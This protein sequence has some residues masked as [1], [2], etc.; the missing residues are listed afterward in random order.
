MSTYGIKDFRKKKI[1]Y[2][3]KRNIECDKAVIE[4]MSLKDLIKADFFVRICKS[5]SRSY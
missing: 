1:D 2:G 5:V 3:L 4:S